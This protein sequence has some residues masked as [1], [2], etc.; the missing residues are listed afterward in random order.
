MSAVKSSYRMGWLVVMFDLPTDT[1]EEKRK[2]ARFRND[3]LDLGYLMLQYSI[4]VRCAVTLDKKKH[5]V[6]ELEKISPGTGSV[7]CLFITDAQWGQMANIC[8]ERKYG[9]RKVDKSFGG[10]QLQFW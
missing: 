1:N 9:P 6:F 3:L 8:D 2:A 10:E 4:Y 5:L 7:K